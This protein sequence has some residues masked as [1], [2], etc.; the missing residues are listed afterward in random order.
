M[1][2]ASI[3]ASSFQYNQQQQQQQ[4]TSL[5]RWESIDV[6]CIRNQQQRITEQPTTSL[7]IT[8]LSS[9]MAISS[10]TTDNNNCEHFA[11]N[12]CDR[13]KNIRQIHEQDREKLVRF[14]YFGQVA[15]VI[16]VALAWIAFIIL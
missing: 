6:G 11:N 3:N 12:Y 10:S 5:A 16:I 14:V 9:S 4:Q 2:L 15:L 7:S 8:S 13:S 1:E